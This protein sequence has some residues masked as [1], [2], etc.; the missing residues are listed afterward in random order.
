MGRCGSI[1]LSEAKE[2]SVLMSTDAGTPS[3]RV[4]GADPYAAVH[5]SGIHREP[6]RRARDLD[7]WRTRQG[8]HHASGVP[9]HRSDA[10]SPVRRSARSAQEHAVRGHGHG[11]WRLHA[12]VLQGLAQR[13][14]RWSARAM[15]SPNGRAS[16]T[17]GWA[18]ARITRPLSWP[19]SARIRSST[20]LSRRM[21]GAGTRRCRRK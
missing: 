20:S 14:R 19:R 8:C 10:G 4:N 11:Q 17:A 1:P 7:L 6:A 9:Q 13:R 5:L 18:A 21:R 16:P 15:P 2:E 3:N 12:Q